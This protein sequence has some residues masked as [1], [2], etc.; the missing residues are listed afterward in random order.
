MSRHRS[1]VDW[2]VWVLTALALV[3]GVSYVALGL[4]V[5]RLPWWIV[6]IYALSAAL[7]VSVSLPLDYDISEGR[8]T[9]R[10]GLV[11]WHIPLESIR[12]AA[13]SNAPWKAPAMSMDR[14]RIEYRQDGMDRSILISPADKGLFLD[15]LVRS[16]RHLRR[17]GDQAVSSE[18][19]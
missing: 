16:S 4:V 18:Q 7:V 15:D 9:V 12:G 10:M 6:G 17:E 2:W 1:K 11:R 3:V 13:P 14:M 5:R 19:T 8:L